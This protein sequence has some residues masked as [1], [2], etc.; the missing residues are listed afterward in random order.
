LFRDAPRKI[1]CAQNKKWARTHWTTPPR[2]EQETDYK[3]K[4]AKGQNRNEA[5]AGWRATGKGS[6]EKRAIFGQTSPFL[7]K[8]GF[9]GFSFTPFSFPL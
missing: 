7:T 8:S 5:K 6:R 1:T 2:S 4:R 3:G 9:E